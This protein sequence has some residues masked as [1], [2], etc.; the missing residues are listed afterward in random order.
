MTQVLLNGKFTDE[1][2]QEFV[3]LFID[4]GFETGEY[5]TKGIDPNEIVRIIFHD[6]N[7]ISFIRDFIL[8]KVLETTIART[9]GWVHTKK[10]EAE[11]QISFQLKIGDDKPVL[12]LSAPDDTNDLVAFSQNIDRL[13]T[14]EFIGSLKKGE[15]IS[16]GWDNTN[17]KIKI[18]RF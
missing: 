8:G 18:V 1:E 13:V 15:M 7:A 17:K 14:V 6:F 10:P 3:S 12:N 4:D 9:W 11:I 16:I 5:I 2:R